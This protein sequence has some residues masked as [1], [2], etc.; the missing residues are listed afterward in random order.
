M[1]PLILVHMHTIIITHHPEKLG[2]WQELGM[3]QLTL[4]SGD[5]QWDIWPDFEP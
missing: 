4:E 3:L 1:H 2:N 5:L